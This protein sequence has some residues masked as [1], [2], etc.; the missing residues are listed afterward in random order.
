MLPVVWLVGTSGV[1]KSTVGW[2]LQQILAR[3]DILAA[4]I[5][6]DQLR[7]TSGVDATED[8]FI[9]DGLAALEPAFANAGARVLIL[10]GIVDDAVHLSRLVPG[11]SRAS[12]FVVHLSASEEVVVR[13][14]EGR[15]W[16][17]DLADESLSYARAFDATWTDLTIDTSDASAADVAEQLV[18]PVLRL[19]AEPDSSRPPG[20][21]LRVPDAN[22]TVITGAGGVGL[23]TAGFLLFLHHAFK[24][25]R[26]GY[27]DSHQLGFFGTDP[28]ASGTAPLR[29]ANTAALASV[30]SSKG[31]E[32]IVLTGD[33]ATARELISMTNP[34]NIFWLDASADA[35][36]ARLRARA[37]GESP[38]AGDHRRGLSDPAIREAV[39]HAV[40]ESRDE[41][42]RPA[43][44]IVIDT[45]RLSAEE[46]A[47]RMAARISS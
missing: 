15:N 38:L 20:P 17:V 8:E 43:S 7:N 24:G 37:A 39:A 2:L 31:V 44:G 19:I 14:I 9:A 36:E 6:A 4:F 45:D 22:L 47:Q 35:I 3:R 18:E 11:A 46:V 26:V 34:R 29:A 33:P 5:D 13:R 23:S 12:I 1:G 32:H 28:R 41:S 10:S 40:A 42:L 16:N 27:I 25:D 21:D 30:M